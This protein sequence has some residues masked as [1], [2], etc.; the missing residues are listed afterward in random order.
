MIMWL[1]KMPSNVAPIPARAARDRSFPAWVLNS[2]RLAPRTSNAWASWS[3]FAS[4]FAPVRWNAVPDP[5]PADLQPPVLGHDRHEPGAADRPPVARSIVANGRSVPASALASA[6]SSQRSSP[7][8]SCGPRDRPAPHRIG[9]R[10]PAPGRPGGRRRRG[11]RRTR[12]PSRTTGWTQ[13][14][15]E[16]ALASGHRSGRSAET[17]RTRRR[18]TDGQSTPTVHGTLAESHDVRST[19]DRRTRHRGH[20]L[21]RLFRGRRLAG[22]ELGPPARPR[23]LA[24]PAAHRRRRRLRRTSGSILTG[25]NGLTLYTYSGDS[26]GTSACTGELRHGLAA[27]HRAVGPAADSGSRGDRHADHPDPR[28]RHDPGRLRRACR[29]TT[30]RATPSRATSPATA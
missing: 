14:C 19:H 3:S 7:A 26:A 27:A 15:C 20:D 29:S 6:A 1:R 13:D 17:G 24:G 22:R 9:R 11:S 21:R 30:G 28:R 8:S 2:T 12:D 5:G 18:R 16:S 4:R 23:Q 10:R 25:P